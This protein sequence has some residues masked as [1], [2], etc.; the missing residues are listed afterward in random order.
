[1]AQ[2][3]NDVTGA[4]NLSF[5]FLEAFHRSLDQVWFGRI[6]KHAC[7]ANVVPSRGQRLTQFGR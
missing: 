1:M 3:T 5:R 7:D 2:S 4:Q 6:Q